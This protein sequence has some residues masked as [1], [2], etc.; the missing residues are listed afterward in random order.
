LVK[1]KPEGAGK[2]FYCMAGWMDEEGELKAE[3]WGR[4]AFF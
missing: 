1:F 3:Y 4:G 2:Y